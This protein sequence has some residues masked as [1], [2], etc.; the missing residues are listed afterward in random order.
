ME[1]LAVRKAPTKNILCADEELKE[2]CHLIL[3]TLVNDYT[4]TD[5]LN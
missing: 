3:I 2:K 5:Q 1:I 4:D